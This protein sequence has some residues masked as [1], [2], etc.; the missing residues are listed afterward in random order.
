MYLLI[1]YNNLIIA[2]PPV[3]NI[4]CAYLKYALTRFDIMGNQKR[5]AMHNSSISALVAS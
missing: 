1:L 2:V 4:E 5:D 3:S